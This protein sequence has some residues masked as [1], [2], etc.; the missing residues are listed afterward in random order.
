MENSFTW[1]I[2]GGEMVA[3]GDGWVEMDGHAEAISFDVIVFR[4]SSQD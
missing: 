2:G 3:D 4:L 1:K